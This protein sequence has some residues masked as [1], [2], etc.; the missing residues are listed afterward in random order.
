MII[1]NEVDRDIIELYC[2]NLHKP[3]YNKDRVFRDIKPT[4]QIDLPKKEKVLK[5]D[6]TITNNKNKV[7]DVKINSSFKKCCAEYVNNPENRISIS[8][9]HPLIKEAHEKL[10]FDKMRALQFSEKLIKNQIGIDEGLIN[11]G[12]EIMNMLNLEPEQL[13]DKSVIKKKLQEIYR[14]LNI[15]KVAKAS[16]LAYWYTIKDH[17]KKIDGRTITKLKVI[18]CN[19]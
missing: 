9:I 16:D 4:I 10:G 12:S 1:K 17:N 6:V 15:K 14:I 7:N 3:I 2:I 18:S 19:I 8:K 13:L 11:L 5:A